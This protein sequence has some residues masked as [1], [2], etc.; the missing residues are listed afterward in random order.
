MKPIKM[1]HYLRIILCS[2]VLMALWSCSDDEREP[3]APSEPDGNDY[4]IM[5]YGSGGDPEHDLSIMTAFTQ[6]AL[7]TADHPEV[8]VT[9]LFK[10]SGKSEGEAHNGVR[11]YTA[12]DGVLVT[13]NSFIPEAD[14][15]ITDP[16]HLT[17]FIRWSAEKYPR[18]KYLLV[19]AGHGLSFTPKNDL[20]VS[21]VSIKDGKN[22]MSAAQFAQG[23]RN[24][25]I[26]LDALIAHSCQQGSVEMLAEWEGLADYLMGSPFS[27]PDLCYDYYH[28]VTDLS[29]G[30][31]VEETLSRSARRTMN[32]WQESHDAGYF[33]TV[34][35]VTRLNDLTPLWET[36]Q[37]TFGHM[38]SSLDDKNF[39]TDPPSVL[40]ATYRDGYRKALY[41]MYNHNKDD[42]FEE[43]RTEQAVDISDFLHNA[44]IYSGDMRLAAYLNRL[45]KVIGDML[46]CHLQ[47]NGKHDFIYNVYVS[48]DLLDAEVLGR[49]RTCRFDRLTGWSDLCGAL[50]GTS[51]TWTAGTVL[52][53]AE[54]ELS[55]G[56]DA[57]FRSE[58]INDNLFSRMWLKS[59]KENCPLDRSELRYL[60]VLH[61]NA[62]G[63]PQRGE[64]VVNAAIADKVTGIFR[65]LYNAGYRIE[66]MVLVDNYNAEDEASM[67][68]N[69]SSSFNFRFIS[70]TTKISKHGYGLAIDINPL[71]NPFVLRQD[72]GSWHIEPVTG[73]AYAFDRENRQDI[74]YKIDHNDLAYKLFTEAGFEWGGDWTTRKDYQ[75]FEIDL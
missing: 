50:L 19:F 70:G 44:Y 10:A 71:Y 12:E 65:Q 25:G 8:A 43:M 39:T 17:D 68:A 56:L 73:N 66:R 67:Q 61:R 52:N 69:N 40:G 14:F 58:E 35:E 16:S 45:D 22:G 37:E 46:V 13:D 9:C 59:W 36:L 20:P 31:S 55:G 26:H 1:R 57:L 60:K 27:I 2:V 62:D 6:G 51:D 38:I 72:D 48:K 54:I 11:R 15:N 4:C 32:L 47:S 53:E 28:L 41:A 64:M 29:E 7:A 30:H 24:S 63:K 34:I 74:P 18:R 75:H 42:F 49:Y 21:R 23:I 3:L 33:G 5:F